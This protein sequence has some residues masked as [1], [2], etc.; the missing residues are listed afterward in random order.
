MKNN[1]SSLFI[2]IGIAIGAA[3]IFGFSSPKAPSAPNDYGGSW[4]MVAA[5]N[6]A[7]YY[8]STAERN[9][10]YLTSST[11]RYNNVT[12]YWAQIKNY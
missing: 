2:G 11:D 12:W 6:G 8:Y 3:A 4:Q 5:S 1:L 9:A 7:V 10:Y